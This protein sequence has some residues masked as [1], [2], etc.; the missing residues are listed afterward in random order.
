[1]AASAAPFQNFLA[2]SLD[3]VT[4]PKS[5]AQAINQG[6]L[7]KIA[8][9]LAVPCDTPATDVVHG[10]SMA[11]SPVSSLGDTL[12]KISVR[13]SGIHKFYLPTGTANYDDP[14]YLTVTDAQTVTV[15]SPGSGAW[16]VGYCRN[17]AAVVGGAGVTVP[18]EILVSPAL[19]KVP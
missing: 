2:E 5:G 7:V 17:I 4:V 15:S 12:T 6:D 8:S 18:V 19:K 11:T 3:Q 9:N 16:V 14:V 10:V 13:R 1:M